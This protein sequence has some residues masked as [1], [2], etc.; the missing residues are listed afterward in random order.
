[1]PPLVNPTPPKETEREHGLAR[2]T[3]PD[4][5]KVA[6]REFDP[7][8]K[9]R[10]FLDA[11]R[12]STYG[13]TSNQVVDITGE[14]QNS[15]NPRSRPLCKKKLLYESGLFH[16]GKS[17]KQAI[18]WRVTGKSYP[19]DDDSIHYGGLERKAPSKK[20]PVASE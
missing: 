11:V 1:M 12:N 8:E 20:K 17:G 13:L 14:Q 3:D 6:A 10:I 9:E 16:R 19:S 2:N 18:V 7:A 15:M 5:S 4:T